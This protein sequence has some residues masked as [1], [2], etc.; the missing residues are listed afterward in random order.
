MGFLDAHDLKQVGCSLSS[1]SHLYK[2]LEPEREMGQ[3]T[4]LE[5]SRVSPSTWGQ[6][7]SDLPGRSTERR[8]ERYR[9]ACSRHRLTERCGL[10]A[11]RQT[12]TFR[13][14]QHFPLEMRHNTVTATA[15][16]KAPTHCLW[17]LSRITLALDNFRAITVCEKVHCWR[18]SPYG[19]LFLLSQGGSS[20]SFKVV[21][22]G[23]WSQGSRPR[24]E[25]LQ[26]T[27]SR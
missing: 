27:A 7:E 2:F 13:N 4:P 24:S 14:R 3:R 9:R 1:L 21:W 5:T 16:L 8:T 17:D 6:T 23:E 22:T 10:K 11:D 20:E 19:L 26:M 25:G 18:S 12:D 15:T